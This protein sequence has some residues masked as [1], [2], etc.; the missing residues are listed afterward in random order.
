MGGT[1]ES[2]RV[3][4]WKLDAKT[5]LKKWSWC[6]SHEI[7]NA[8]QYGIIQNNTPQQNFSSPMLPV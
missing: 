2:L 3:N 1:D 6:H 5:K 8:T 7:F 4:L